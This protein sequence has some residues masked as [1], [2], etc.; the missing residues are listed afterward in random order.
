M[1]IYT[2]WILEDKQTGERF[3]HIKKGKKAP[4]ANGRY[5]I[6]GCCGYHEKPTEGRE[7][8]ND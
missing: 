7:T 8:K 2:H 4:F 3:E 1:E 6:I 5:I